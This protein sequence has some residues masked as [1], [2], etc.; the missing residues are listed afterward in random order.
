MLPPGRARFCDHAQRLGDLHEH[1]RRC[2]RRLLQGLCGCAAT[3][4]QDVRREGHEFGRDAARAFGIVIAPADIDAQIAALAPAEASE[5][6][7]EDR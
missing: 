7:R 1:D 3:R 2:A 5:R 6:A 4:Q